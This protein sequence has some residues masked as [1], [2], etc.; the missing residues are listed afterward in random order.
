M[1]KVLVPTTPKRRARVIEFLNSCLDNAGIEHEV[2]IFENQ[3]GGFV[4]AIRAM[5]DRLEDDDPIVLMN[6]DVTFGKDWLKILYEGFMS[7]PGIELAQSR[8]MCNP[9]PYHNNQAV[10]PMGRPAFFRKFAYRG[11]HH[12]F[13]DWEWTEIANQRGSYLY[14]PESIIYHNHWTF[15]K[16]TRDETYLTQAPYFDTDEA[17]F[18]KRFNESNGF[19][20]WRNLDGYTK[21]D[22]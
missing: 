15:G 9:M 21:L 1:I 8:E 12:N 4:K 3:L 17:L 20:E 14:V 10:L 5:V 7:R 19:K 22:A 18:H 16:S 11:Y 6:D 2:V 13:V